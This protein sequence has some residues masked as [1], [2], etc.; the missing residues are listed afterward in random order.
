MQSNVDRTDSKAKGSEVSGIH[1]RTQ[2]KT[3]PTTNVQL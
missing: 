1:K 2:W 3:L